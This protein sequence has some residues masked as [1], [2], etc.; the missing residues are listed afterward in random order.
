MWTAKM[1]LELLQDPE[2]ADARISAAFHSVILHFPKVSRITFLIGRSFVIDLCQVPVSY[3]EAKESV[4]LTPVS[5]HSIPE[6][7]FL[8]FPIQMEK[9]WLSKLCP[10]SLSDPLVSML[11]FSMLSLRVIGK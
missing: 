10:K 7:Y 1:H 6:E 4:S 9:P 3:P 5:F 8:L 11:S 2:L